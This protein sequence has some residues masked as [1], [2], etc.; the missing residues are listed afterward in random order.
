MNVAP[1]PEQQQELLGE[2][3]IFIARAKGLECRI[4]EGGSLR[5]IQKIDEKSLD[6]RVKD[7]EAVLSRADTEGQEFLQV[8]FC[9]G[10]KILVTTT[11]VGFADSISR[12][13]LA[14]SLL[15]TYS[16]SSKPSKTHFMPSTPTFTK[17]QY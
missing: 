14:S 13:S 7:L 1:S 4:L 3:E 10:K 16:V 12:N 8:N 15:Q 9:S 11:L 17:F 2:I 5:I 6:L